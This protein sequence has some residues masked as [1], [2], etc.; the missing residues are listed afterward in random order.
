[1]GAWFWRAGVPQNIE[2]ASEREPKLLRNFPATHSR[3][4]QPDHF[5][6]MHIKD[7]RSSK[8]DSMSLCSSQA[9]RCAFCR[10][11]SLG[12]EDA[13]HRV[14]KCLSGRGINDAQAR[15]DTR[16]PHGRRAPEPCTEPLQTLAQLPQTR[17]QALRVCRARTARMTSP[18]VLVTRTS[19][20][21][22]LAAYSASALLS[23]PRA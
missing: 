23:G 14:Q 16:R 3:S 10:D 22:R 20:Q 7:A 12:F 13:P 18:E 8:L 4:P 17:A 11:C 6:A 9:M 1:M 2:H 5:A 21:P 19:S 15:N